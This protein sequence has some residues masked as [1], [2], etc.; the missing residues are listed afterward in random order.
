MKFRWMFALFFSGLITLSAREPSPLSTLE[1]LVGEWTDLRTAIATERREWTRQKGFLERETALLRKELFR[2]RSEKAEL[3][4]VGSTAEEREAE[5]S[6]ER[7]GL[8]ARLDAFRPVLDRAEAGLRRSL[9]RVPE[10][11]VGK[12]DAAGRLPASAEAAEDL[13]VVDRAQTLASLMTALEDLQGEIHLARRLLPVGGNRERQVEVLYLGMAR[14]F[15]V[16]ANDDWAAVGVPGEN[17]WTWTPEPDLA[18]R[19]RAA[20]SV[21]EQREPARLVRL[22]LAVENETEA[23]P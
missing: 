1:G 20:V 21:L 14:G 4:E 7:D 13:R 16:S 3:R 11:L 19:A 10:P 22:P 8:R 9:A 23:G 12:L 5:L 15:A 18:A 6:A 17:G 2:L